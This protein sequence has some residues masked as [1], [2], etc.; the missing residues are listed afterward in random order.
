MG[1][2][3]VRSSTTEAAAQQF[4]RAGEGGLGGRYVVVVSQ[5]ATPMERRAGKLLEAAG[6]R[7]QGSGIGE[8]EGQRTIYVGPSLTS[9]TLTG[10]RVD[11]GTL[12]PDGVVISKADN[13]DLVLAGG[14][15]RGT[16]HSVVAF[17]EEQAGCR[18]W[19]D[20]THL[21][22]N[23]DTPAKVTGLGG[24]G[25]I[26]EDGLYESIDGPAFRGASMW[27]TAWALGD[28]MFGREP[29][30]GGDYYVTQAAQ[31]LDQP[32]THADGSLCL[33][34]E[35]LRKAVAESVRQDLETIYPKMRRVMLEVGRR[36]ANTGH[37]CEVCEELEKKTGS[38]ASIL[39]NFGNAITKGITEGY[40]EAKIVLTFEGEAAK[41]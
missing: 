7:I 15:P 40:P 23:I 5:S 34:D 36:E 26:E 27:R 12:G 1:P 31:S 11:W 37:A 20:G 29:T 21:Y 3:C 17:L 2:F 32:K 16:A 22:P 24:L 35:A 18:W 38:P 14:R 6:F 30:L 33:S 10:D 41:P 4:P 28:P 8:R 25:G 9:M 13:S 19:P 39:V